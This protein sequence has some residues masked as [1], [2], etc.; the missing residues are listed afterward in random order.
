MLGRIEQSVTEICQASRDLLSWR[1]WWEGRLV[2]GRARGPAWAVG[3]SC[4]GGCC[5]T[6]QRPAERRMGKAAAASSRPIRPRDSRVRPCARGAAAACGH[7]FLWCASYTGG[8][9]QV[10]RVIADA[11]AQLPRKGR[12]AVRRTGGASGPGS[13]AAGGSKPFAPPAPP[14][15]GDM[16]S[17]SDDDDVLTSSAA[18]QHGPMALMDM[19]A[20]ARE[21]YG[22]GGGSAA[23]GAKRREQGKQLEQTAGSVAGKGKGAKANSQR[24]GATSAARRHSDEGG[25]GRRSAARADSADVSQKRRSGHKGHRRR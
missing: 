3:G 13:L 20:R 8:R 12:Q 15:V 21:A 17:S 25:R 7:R 18:R 11:T 14:G 1:G 23:S 22:R 9:V 24:Q 2:V 19:R 16:E 6:Q 4:D 5:R 10:D